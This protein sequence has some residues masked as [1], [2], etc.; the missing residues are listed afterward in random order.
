MGE[1]LTH[2]LQ[3][4]ISIIILYAIYWVFLK[5]DTFFSLNRFYLLGA[6]AFS[7]VIPF[8][9]INFGLTETNATFV[10]FLETIQISADKIER[11]FFQNMDVYETILIVYIT[12]ASLFLIRL[13]FQLGQLTYFI[14]RSDQTKLDKFRLIYHKKF[15][16]PFS[17][18]NLIFVN[19][20]KLNENNFSDILVHEKA[21]S[22]QLHTLDLIFLE[23]LT[24][25][26]WFNPIIWLYRS[27]I[28]EIHE[29]LADAEVLSNGADQKKYFELLLNHNLGYQINDLA[30][31]FQKSLIKKRMLMMKKQRSNPL[32]KFKVLTVVPAAILLTIVI[33]VS[34]ADVLNASGSQSK[35]SYKIYS[36]VDVMPG[37]GGDNSTL[38][39]YLST[40]IIYPKEAAKQGIQGRVYVSFV[41]EID[42]SVSGVRI[43]R[44][45]NSL[46][47]QEA[48][49]VV[50]AMPK[51]T[52]GTV[53][54]KAVRVEFNL[55]IQFKLEK[56][57]DN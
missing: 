53:E 10:V 8:F 18:F 19:K 3:T 34:T 21:H 32:S 9:K 41:V 29:Y 14:S 52:P 48:V 27:S 54:G 15:Y 6:L 5:K 56:K 16:L 55:P 50:E 13:F 46:L 57:E 24:I 28:K 25:F 2:I 11:S 36:V 31:N 47:D 22:N 35:E 45:V 43:L 17:F 40:N 37:F 33:A 42:G 26:Q 44:G 38:S 20:E 4:T 51:W 49:R 39:N 12:G 1:L 30:N 23:L 7:V